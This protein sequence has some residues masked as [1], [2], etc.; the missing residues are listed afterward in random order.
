MPDAIIRA[1]AHYFIGLLLN[2][3]FCEHLLNNT[4]GHHFASGR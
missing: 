2:K 4:K 1:L 3:N